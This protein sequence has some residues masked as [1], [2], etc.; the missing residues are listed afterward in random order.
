MSKRRCATIS[1]HWFEQVEVDEAFYQVWMQARG[2]G[3]L[4]DRQQLWIPSGRGRSCSIQRSWPIPCD[5]V[6][7]PE[8]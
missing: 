2:V 5:D 8:A 3:Q 4:L 6:A 1:P 7:W